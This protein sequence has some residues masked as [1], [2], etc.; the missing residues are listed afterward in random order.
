MKATL[1]ADD[2]GLFWA[3]GRA[4]EGCRRLRAGGAGGVLKLS[5]RWRKEIPRA[6]FWDVYPSLSIHPSCLVGGAHRSF[7]Q[8]LWDCTVSTSMIGVA[9]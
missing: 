9:L 3:V 8:K 6:V 1:V 4:R 2:G 7:H 5:T